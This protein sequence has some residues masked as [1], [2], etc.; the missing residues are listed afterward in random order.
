M[1]FF[2]KFVG[3]KILWQSIEVVRSR[4]PTQEH[5]QKLRVREPHSQQD[6]DVWVGRYGALLDIVQGRRC[7]LG[8][9]PRRETEWFA[10]GRD[11]QDLFSRTAIGLFHA[12]AWREKSDYLN[13]EAC[14]AADAYMAVQSTLR[15]RL[16]VLYSL[17]GRGR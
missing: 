11:W 3:R 1:V 16:K 13:I 12:P 17:V 5:L 7:W 8:L 14:D 15:G 2:Q 9:R 4:L 6:L 10:L